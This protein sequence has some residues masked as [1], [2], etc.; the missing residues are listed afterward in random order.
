MPAARTTATPAAPAWLAS[1]LRWRP[2]KNREKSRRFAKNRAFWS[3]PG[4]AVDLERSRFC[5]P[6]FAGFRRSSPVFCW[7]K[8]SPRRV[9]LPFSGCALFENS[10]IFDVSG[11][12]RGFSIKTPKVRYLT[13]TTE[14]PPEGPR[15][16]RFFLGLGRTHPRRAKRRRRDSVPLCP[17]DMY[18][19]RQCRERYMS[20]EPSV[21]GHS[22]M[23]RRGPEAMARWGR[24]SHSLP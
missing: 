20:P 2:V 4:P 21:N 14:V 17:G 15:F 11:T 13:A 16:R 6:V 1:D 22:C 9:D 12:K 23:S 3:R 7:C 5:S 19:S 10:T 24:K 8:Y 18:R